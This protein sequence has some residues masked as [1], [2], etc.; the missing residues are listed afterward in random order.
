MKLTKTDKI[1]M[2]SYAS[3]IE[4]LSKYLGSAYEISLHNLEDYNHSVV[5]I[6]NGYHS[7][8]SVGAPLTDLA[9]NMIKRITTQGIDSSGSYLS[10][11]AINNEGE[12]TKSS[13]IPVIGEKGRVIGIICINF[14]LDTPLTEIMDS[15]I[16]SKKEVRVNEHFAKSPT[17]A[18]STMVINTKKVVDANTNILPSNKNKEIIRIL[19]ENGV[20]NLKDSVIEVA[21]QLK[22]SKNTV[23]LHL[24][25]IMEW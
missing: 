4:G 6:M 9:L 20:F 24:R 7:G 13:S 16:E 15:L 19:Y 2:S 11:F 10:Y 18:V 3:M 12:K 5:K 8:R 22:I 25:S 23:Y 14:Y 17:E 1:I 21:K